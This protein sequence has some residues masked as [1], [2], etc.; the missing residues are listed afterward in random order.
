MKPL[1]ILFISPYLP[2]Q[3]RA[4]PYNLIKHLA[5]RGHRITLLAL[6]PSGEDRSG[7][8]SLHTWCQR[9]QITPLPRWRPL[10]N[11]IQAIASQTPFQAAYS[12]SPEMMELI[13]KTQAE[14]NFDIIHVEHLR[15][16][17]LSRAVKGGPI[18]FDSVDSITLLFDL[19]RR[20]GPT[21]RSRLLAN[22]DLVRTRRY[23]GQLLEKYPRVLVTSPRDRE[24]LA[25]LSALAVKTSV[26]K[27]GQN[28]DSQ[29]QKINDCLVII[30]IGVDLDYFTPLNIPRDPATLIFSG[31]MS[32]HANTAAALDLA[33]K[34]MPVVW[35]R[36][37]E[38]RLVLAGKNPPAEVLA[39]SADPRIVVTGTVPDL[40]PYL[41][42]ATLAVSPMRYAVGM[43]FKVLEAMA[44]A[45]P[46]ISTPQAVSALQVQAGQE[47]LVADTPQAVADAAITLLTNET[48]RQQVGQQGRRYVETHHDWH[49][50]AEKLESV[51]YDVIM[52]RRAVPV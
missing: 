43:Q 52:E 11:G 4:R 51:Y 13:K 26:G 5:Q 18:V 47:A 30:P 50:A 28:S 41:A 35:Q 6:E 33:N 32:Y 7:L 44:M 40:R 24:A 2:S 48:L 17:E 37:P 1:N 15:G 20:S 31:K 45:T 27:A 34:I 25:Q 22:L 46:L 14:T 9:V 29:M 49:K 36:L 39:L 16:A 10:W 21:W 42:Q 8:N 23:E 12:R 3:I 38:T 19:V